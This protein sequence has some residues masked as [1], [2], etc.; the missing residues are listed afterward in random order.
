M[1]RKLLQLF[2]FS[3]GLLVALSLLSAIG[4]SPTI[5]AWTDRGEIGCDNERT[6]ADAWRDLAFDQ[7]DIQQ[8]ASL[9]D[10]F[11]DIRAVSGGKVF[12]KKGLDGEAVILDDAWLN[13]SHKAFEAILAGLAK[14]RAAIE[15]MHARHCANIA[16]TRE[17]FVEIR[18]LNTVWAS[19]AGS[20]LPAQMGRLIEELRR[21]RMNE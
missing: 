13:E 12:L 11:R 15:E 5:A 7:I 18:R 9:A 21:E 17:A 3:L 19:L 14:R 10:V 6:A 20:D 8:S 4:C 2:L 16:G 1:K